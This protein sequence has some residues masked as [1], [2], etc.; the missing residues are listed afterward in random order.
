MVSSL[1]SRLIL[2]TTGAE[3]L[4]GKGEFLFAPAGRAGGIVR[5][6]GAFVSDAEIASIVKHCANYIQ[7][8]FSKVLLSEIEGGSYG[9]FLN[10]GGCLAASESEDV[11]ELY[12]RCVNLV[13]TERRA[14]TSLLQRRFS[15]GYGR[16]AKILDMMEQRGI[17]GPNMGASRPREVLVS[18]P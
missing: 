12:T 15:I 8:G 3:T 2:D 1:D 13:A 16:A 14:S 17:I 6:Q 18:H 11:E 7:Q 9:S 4:K 5:A 10:N